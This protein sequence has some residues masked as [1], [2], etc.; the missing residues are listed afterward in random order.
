MRS[1]RP[2]K[3]GS[4]SPASFTSKSRLKKDSI[5]SPHT[6]ARPTTVGAMIRVATLQFSGM[7]NHI[8]AHPTK[9]PRR[10]PPN[11]AHVLFGLTFGARRG[12]PIKEP[13]ANAKMSERATPTPTRSRISTPWTSLSLMNTRYDRKKG[14]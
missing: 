3:P 6:A 7:T 2:P 1:R 4:R 10:L 11:P 14:M 8:S 9:A 13:T 5:R 12:P